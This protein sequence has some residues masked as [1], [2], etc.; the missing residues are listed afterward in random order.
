[1]NVI[2][3]IEKKIDDNGLIKLLI[4]K[5]LNTKQ[6]RELWARHKAKLPTFSPWLISEL[7]Q[8]ED[9]ADSHHEILEVGLQD[10]EKKIKS[11]HDIEH[12]LSIETLPADIKDVIWSY[13]S[14]HF[15][16]LIE[17]GYD[18][19]NILR[20][21]QWTPSQFD[22]L[23]QYLISH[24]EQYMG[25]LYTFFNI[26]DTKK[27]S[28][29]LKDKL[30]RYVIDNMERILNNNMGY[31][32]SQTDSIVKLYS[33]GEDVL[34]KQFRP[35]FFA[36]ILSQIASSQENRIV[37][38]DGFLIKMFSIDRLLFN[39]KQ[40][41]ELLQAI[42]DFIFKKIDFNLEALFALDKNEL[43]QANREYIWRKMTKK[44]IKYW[45]ERQEDRHVTYEQL[46]P[47]LNKVPS[48]GNRHAFFREEALCADTAD[49]QNHDMGMKN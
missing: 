2:E 33:S 38:S 16:T 11:V 17:R 39:E 37:W 12:I 22:E 13:C 41:S 48:A 42:P 40:R 20:I 14:K 9:L 32:V 23:T 7:I 8:I 31:I 27:L 49:V 5:D 1:M 4:L 18:M 3:Y 47:F 21:K 45:L 10:I 34:P 26:L 46:N 30:C 15:S 35:Q 29:E 43:S 28:P 19:V 36:S 24:L 6:K 44:S 25:S